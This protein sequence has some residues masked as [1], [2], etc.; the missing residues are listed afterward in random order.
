MFCA[1]GSLI[2]EGRLPAANAGEASSLLDQAAVLAAG[3]E[4]AALSS[5]GGRGYTEG[6]HVEMPGRISKHRCSTDERLVS[7]NICLDSFFLPV[8]LVCREKNH[9]GGN[10]MFSTND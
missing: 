4:A 1:L 7:N 3:G 6:P 5:K 8:E 2:A 10:K 9:A